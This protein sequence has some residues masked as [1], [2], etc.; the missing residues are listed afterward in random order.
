MP[1]PLPHRSLIC[2][3]ISLQKQHSL[4][5][6]FYSLI[7]VLIFFILTGKVIITALPPIST[8]G[9]NIDDVPSFTEA[10]RK[11]MLFTYNESSAPRL[12]SNGLN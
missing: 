5:L 6:H 2:S 8:E 11:Q 10:I 7:F 9:K 1:P 4:C 3:C 12:E